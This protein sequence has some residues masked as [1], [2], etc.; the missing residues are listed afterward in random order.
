M[1]GIL[2]LL[3]GLVVLG[4][5]LLGVRMGGLGLGL[6]GIAGTAL[7]VFVL[8][9]D[10]GSP[11]VAA[12]FIIIAVITASAAMQ[13]AGGID[14]LVS[15]ASRIIR[16]YPSRITFVAPLVGFVFTLGAGTGNLFIALVP[17]IYETSYRNGIRP[18]R[19]LAAATVTSS[20]GIIA[21]PV[22]AAMAAY[23]TLLPN[24]FGLPQILAITIPASIVACLVTSAVQQR[25][26]AELVDDPEFLRRVESG[27]L[28]PPPR[29]AAILAE[30]AGVPVAALAGVS[31]AALAGGSVADHDEA[32][33]G[34]LTGQEDSANLVSV[35]TEVPR[36]GAR[37][38]YIFLTGV[39]LIV[40]LGLFSN[41]R[42]MITVDDAQQR[43]DMSTVIQLIMFT[44]AL[45]I[46]VSSRVKA[47]DLLHQPLLWHG[48][49]AAVALFGIAWMADTFIAGNKKTIVEPLGRLVVEYPLFLAVAIFLV[50][51]L[52]TSQSTTTRTMVP[53]ALAAT[54]A[55]ATITALWPSMVGI[56]LFPAN[57]PQIASV[58]I[59]QTGSTRFSQ[60]PIWHSFTIPMLVCWVS[61]V[62]TG[63]LVSLLM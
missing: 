27:A 34:R 59:D 45:L 2:V 35:V 29:V 19:P 48:F 5:I 38:A 28:V 32:A 17:V 42:P 43:L 51:A 16:R 30:R 15:V 47:P 55:P 41:L 62:G 8:G 40:L 20:L 49:V 12:F 23:L 4:A 53:I 26:G 31:V 39:V 21:S 50:A 57:G 10:P 33:P 1:D 9:L 56:W 6:W 58:A 52:T 37:S 36:G 44:A 46:L 11:P 14:F 3:Q 18:E 63:L 60:V 25:I 61:A 13:A 7:L 54:L 22:S 24:G